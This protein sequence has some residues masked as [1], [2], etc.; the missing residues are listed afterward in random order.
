MCAFCDGDFSNENDRPLT[1]EFLLGYHC[2]RHVLF[3]SKSTE[4]DR[5][6]N[7]DSK[8]DLNQGE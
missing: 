3:S 2:Q 4:G 1:G 6:E 8:T 7:I 5:V